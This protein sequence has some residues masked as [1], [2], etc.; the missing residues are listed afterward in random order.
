MPLEDAPSDLDVDVAYL[1]HFHQH[2][3]Q[4]QFHLQGLDPSSEALPPFYTN[5]PTSYWTSAEKSAFFHG[6]SVYSRLRPDLIADSVQTKNVVEVCTYIHMLDEGLKNN[7]FGSRLKREEIEGAMEV[8]EE[9]IELEEY[10]SE[11]IV[12]N[13]KGW[14]ENAA[15]TAREDERKAMK[16]NIRPRATQ[17]DGKTQEDHK[18]ARTEYKEWE[19]A[20]GIVWEKED[21]LKS[22][23]AAHC[24]VIDHILRDFEEAYTL[25]LH[26]NGDASQSVALEHDESMIDPVLRSSAS[27]AASPA[28]KTIPDSLSPTSRRRL[29]KRLWMRRKRERAKGNTDLSA[30]SSSLNLERIKPGRKKRKT[31]SGSQVQIPEE[32]DEKEEVD[33][34]HP[35]IGGKTQHYKIKAQFEKMGID[36]SALNQHG[37]GLFH[38]SALSKVMKC[39]SNSSENTRTNNQIGCIIYSL[40]YPLQPLA[41]SRQTR[42]SSFTHM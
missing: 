8:S 2:V 26:N 32:D 20:Q 25:S 9:W 14:E 10:H 22:L 6:L 30:A 33:P 36:G 21:V 24:K 4:T 5:N 29:Q 40:T 11:G 31:E 28:V 35:H 13:E 42:S 17:G 27:R 38:M 41:R 15:A 3:R 34:R 12:F 23:G 19:K 37:L 7:A 1:P 39:V 18:R 16:K